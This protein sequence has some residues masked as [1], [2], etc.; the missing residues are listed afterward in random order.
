MAIREMKSYNVLQ[1]LD[2]RWH[3]KF[4]AHLCSRLPQD[5]PTISRLT[6]DDSNR[7]ERKMS[8]HR[9]IQ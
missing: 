6:L 1:T 8:E 5:S 3:L 7:E 9:V 2:N 4:G